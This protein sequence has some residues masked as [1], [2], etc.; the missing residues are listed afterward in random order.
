M[1][2]RIALAATALSATALLGCAGAAAAHAGQDDLVPLCEIIDPS[3][4][5]PTAATR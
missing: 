4:P 3:K 5:A 1:R 2:G